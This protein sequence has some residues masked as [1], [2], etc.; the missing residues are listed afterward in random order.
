MKNLLLSLCILCSTIS[1]FSQVYYKYHIIDAAEAN[2]IYNATGGSAWTNHKNWPIATGV[3]FGY[4]IPSGVSFAFGDTTILSYPPPALDTG[5]VELLIKELNLPAN[6]MS[7]TLP[8]FSLDSLQVV[9]VSDN[10]FSTL[11][12]FNLPS[13]RSFSAGRCGI[14]GALVQWNTPKL[15]FVYLWKN[16]ITS[17]AADLTYSELKYL[18]LSENAIQGQLTQ[19]N[20]PKLEYLNLG[21][22]KL[23]G[24]SSDLVYPYL[25]FFDLTFNNISGD[26]PNWNF[27]NLK[28]LYL[29]LNNFTGNIPSFAYPLM[30][31]FRVESNNLSGEIPDFNWPNLKV[32]DAGDNQLTGDLPL[33]N[34]P[35]LE[36]YSLFYNQLTGDLKN[37]NFPALKYLWLNDNQLNGVIQSPINLPAL[38]R[39]ELNENKLRGPITSLYLPEVQYF[40]VQ[41]NDF[42][43][44]FPYAAM[45]KLKYLVIDGNNFTRLPDYTGGSPDLYEVS[46]WYNKFHFDDL[47]PYKDLG[48]FFYYEMQPVDMSASPVGDSIRLS[49]NVRGAGN[50]YTWYKG[51]DNIVKV[52]VDVFMIYKTEKPEDY[53]CQ[54]TNPLLPY[55]TLHSKL[56]QPVI[57]PCWDNGIFSIC[58]TTP[59]EGWEKGDEANEIQTTLPLS[60]N[61]FI[62]FEGSIILDTVD[63][64]MKINGKFYLENILLPG[65]NVGNFTLAQGKYTLALAG[66]DGSITGFIND[67]LSTYVPQIGG[68]KI[69][70]EKLKLVGGFH[71]T[72]VS[73][74]FKVSWDNIVPSCGS[75]STQTTAIS[76]EGLKITVDGFDVGGVKVEDLGFA[77]KFCLKKFLA[78][79]DRPK[80]KLTFGLTILTP[81]IEVG[82]GLG[83]A[84]GA[85]D[86][87]AMKAELQ[88]II[89]PIGTTGIGVIGCEGWVSSIKS[90]P[91]NMR[92]GG[93]FSA[94]VNDDLFRLTTSV[95]YIPPAELK[96]EA[97]D[98]KFFNTHFDDDWWLIEGGIYGSVNFK[99]ESMKAG[100]QIKIAPYKS[101]DTKKFIGNGSIDMSYRNEAN[102]LA[103]KFNGS[104]T[105]P[106]LSN[107]WPF[108]W[109]DS[110]LNL[111]YTATANGVLVYK[112]GTKFI[113]GTIN[114]SS[115]IGDL[116]YRIE[117][118]KPFTD[119]DYLTLTVVDGQVTPVHA[120]TFDYTFT[121][122]DQT[123]MAVVK[124]THTTDLPL[125]ALRQPDGTEISEA[126]PSANAELD[127]DIVA[128]KT[129]WTLYTPQ[130]GLWT[131][132]VEPDADINVYYF[133]KPSL[134][135]INATQEPDGL[136]VSWDPSLFAP[137]DSID[138]FADDDQE[139]FDGVYMMTTGATTGAATI[140][141]ALFEN[142][143]AFNLQALAYQDQS[144][145]TDYAAASFTNSLSS[146]GL[147]E[148]I[149]VHF[150]TQ[151]LLIEA[152]WTPSPHP[153][154]A[155]Y[156]IELVEN[157][158]SRVIGMPYSDQ[159][160]FTYQLDAYTGQKLVI[161]AYGVE[162]EVS[163][164]SREYE[165][166]TSAVE[167]MPDPVF[168]E[169]LFVYPNPF[170]DICTIRIT[171]TTSKEGTL[172]V[173]NS[174]GVLLRTVPQVSL[175]KG[176]N[177]LPL[178][179]SEMPP[180]SYFI[181]FHSANAVLTSQ[182]IL[183]K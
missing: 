34:S 117:L 52:G 174:Q 147:P 56:A 114:F 27:P 21:A 122:P 71:A 47:L 94:V 43:G 143:C 17:V 60:I 19:W 133:G 44:E 4:K 170:T 100:G 166:S 108:D 168:T 142:Q 22:N 176:V 59:D 101:G 15:Q 125:V 159:N 177:D 68:L 7:G 178:S 115:R 109:L 40:R 148:D 23:S 64:E 9:D 169:N 78:N 181:T 41:N 85:V 135:S 103:G 152:S 179:M 3:T 89:I 45:P 139:N 12:V 13:L 132:A 128:H 1:G 49:V 62:L 72:G 171:S 39:F 35:G 112:T 126:I 150:N 33:L 91:W 38:I 18:N 111:P 80:D 155:G 24:V 154:I 151:S 145:L 127:K 165:L 48:R 157:G 119:P 87:I 76:I 180:G 54:I 106:K 70:L 55:L 118:A 93:I 136:H 162:G 66:S 105:V 30:E 16:N 116:Q 158:V 42:S 46:C 138:F 92:F 124:A 20:T 36:T 88:N 26:L 123:T 149:V 11:P 144:L 96:I 160:T 182:I 82:A 102:A 173:F 58:I 131:A 81:F 74:S 5:I 99:T 53:E 137:T 57:P 156:V 104:F 110:K 95:E 37:L 146:F 164:A 61:D 90:P 86:S 134:F 51:H 65:G 73:L 163:C 129:F 50:E 69:K 172:R 10:S 32:F 121:V 28:E 79:Y 98:G 97:G 77:P 107:S 130:P 113:I 29:S 75:T 31:I 153:N 175:L 14:G 6:N 141:N 84:G 8:A 83:L 120:A 167:E 140:P 67:A 25:Y 183:V 161:Y 63:L 2:K